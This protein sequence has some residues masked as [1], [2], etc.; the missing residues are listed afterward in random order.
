MFRPNRTMVA[1]RRSFFSILSIDAGVF[2]QDAP[3]WLVDAM[4]KVSILSI[5][6]GVFRQSFFNLAESPFS[7]LY[8]PP[9]P[10][11]TRLANPGDSKRKIEPNSVERN[12]SPLPFTHPNSSKLMPAPWIAICERYWLACDFFHSLRDLHFA[13]NLHTMRFKES[14]ICHPNLNHTQQYI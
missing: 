8:H 2:R 4:Q 14:V 9:P 3:E 13:P 6:A 10:T 11:C 1:R 7:A 5:E 12:G